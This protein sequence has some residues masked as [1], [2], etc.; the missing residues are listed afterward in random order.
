MFIYNT[1]RKR[2]EFWSY[3]LLK[4]GLISA[5][6]TS[7]MDRNDFYTIQRQKERGKI[8]NV[9]W[10]DIHKHLQQ[11]KPVKYFIAI[12]AGAICVALAAFIFCGHVQ[13]M[14]TAKCWNHRGYIQG[15]QRLSL[16]CHDPGVIIGANLV[17]SR[18]FGSAYKDLSMMMRREMWYWR[19]L[20]LVKEFGIKMQ[21]IKRLKT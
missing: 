7:N 11:T 2:F 17:G 6:W 12:I 4:N 18:R 5:I 10:A 19:F 14:N 20:V 21:C 8:V 1:T 16:D 3:M 15:C 9:R 13:G